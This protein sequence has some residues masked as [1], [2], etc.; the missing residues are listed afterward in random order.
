MIVRIEID[1][2]EAD[3]FEY[4]VTDHGETLF[5][6]AGLSS[7]VES[8]ASAVEGL[9]PSVVGVEIWFRGIVSGTY[10]LA[11]VAMS[12]DQIAEHAVNTT[13]AI[14]EVM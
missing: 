1:R 5:G 9:A 7:V 2:Y 13:A 6:D 10:P 4:Q 3:T 14:E 11:V 8:I 12:S